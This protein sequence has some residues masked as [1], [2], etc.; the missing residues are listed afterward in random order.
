M[1]SKS[2][3]VKDTRAWLSKFFFGLASQATSSSCARLYRGLEM[4]ES[5]EIIAFPLIGRMQT[6]DVTEINLAAQI[7]QGNVTLDEINI[8]I[9]ARPGFADWMKWR[10]FEVWKFGVVFGRL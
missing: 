8:R 5:A 9:D 2:W 7:R 3:T 1:S 4:I 10:G 6:H